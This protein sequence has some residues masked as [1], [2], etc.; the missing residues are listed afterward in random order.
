MKVAADDGGDGD[1]D[2]EV[3]D[4][5]ALTFDAGRVLL[6]LEDPKYEAY[7]LLSCAP[8]DDMAGR[9]SALLTSCHLRPFR[10]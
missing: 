10:T 2:E 4:E 6:E 1:G 7:A 8:L 9:P 3:T 5:E